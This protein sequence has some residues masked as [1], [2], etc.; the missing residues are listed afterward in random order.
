M[1]R[2]FIPIIIVLSLVFI[3]FT[4]SFVAKHFQKREEKILFNELERKQKELGEANNKIELLKLAKSINNSN[5]TSNV[6]N[7]ANDKALLETDNEYY[8]DDS[9]L[10]DDNNNDSEQK[11]EFKNLTKEKNKQYIDAKDIKNYIKN[12]PTLNERI[13]ESKQYENLDITKKPKTLNEIIEE[14]KQYERIIKESELSDSEKEELLKN[15]YEIDLNELEDEYVLEKFNDIDS[16]TEQWKQR[17]F[18][19]FRC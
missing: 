16:R 10:Y 8:D 14:S 4:S 2:I 13:E 19:F 18:L 12:P 6:S 7:N 9:D 17:L 1:S 5:S 15:K 11:V 3:F